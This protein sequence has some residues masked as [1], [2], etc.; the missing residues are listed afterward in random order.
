[1]IELIK[2]GLIVFGL[3]FCAMSGVCVAYYVITSVFE[4][5]DR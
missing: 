1:M 2:S 3:T 5:F 4:L